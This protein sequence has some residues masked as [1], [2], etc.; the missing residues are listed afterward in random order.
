MHILVTGGNGFI[1][2]Q[3]VKQLVAN[4][5]NVRCSFRETS[6]RRRL[7]GLPYEVVI[8]DVRN[9]LSILE[10]VNGCD[11]IIHCASLSNWKDL[12]SPTL[13]SIIIEGTRNLIDAAMAQGARMVYVSSAA[14]LG[15]SRDPL[16]LRT[17]NSEFNLSRRAY[18]YAALKAEADRMCMEA[19]KMHGADIITVHPTETYGPGDDQHV[20]AS[21]LIEFA[22]GKACLTTKGGTSVVHVEDVAAGIVAACEKGKTGAKYVL[23]GENCTISR[24]AEITRSVCGLP[25]HEI[26]IPQWLLLLIAFGFQLSPFTKA[27]TLAIKYRYAAHYWYFDNTPT[28]EALGVKFRSPEET[29]RAT[30]N[31]L[32]TQPNGI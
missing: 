7:K 32:K 31:W 24:I 22:R 18:K 20:T 19:V 2:S 17:A 23:G 26:R 11:A 12:N 30:I 10:A 14:A 6:D 13:S 15:A 21:T 16:Q 29:L 3:V 28:I 8:A 25:F 9:R 27:K 5:H 4:G 1:G